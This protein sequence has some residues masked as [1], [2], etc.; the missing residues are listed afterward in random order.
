MTCKLLYIFYIRD[1]GTLSVCPFQESQKQNFVSSSS[2]RC[3][4][5]L[6]NYLIILLIIALKTALVYFIDEGSP[7]LSGDKLMFTNAAL[8]Y[9][10][11]VT[12]HSVGDIRN[13]D[14]DHILPKTEIT[15]E[16]L[17]ICKTQRRIFKVLLH[18]KDV[19]RSFNGDF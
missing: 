16:I 6:I 18:S 2:C 4:N 3:C 1:S 9:T 14:D 13:Y 12:V 7:C 5:A 8:I 15:Q 10:H 19:N 17:F 11:K